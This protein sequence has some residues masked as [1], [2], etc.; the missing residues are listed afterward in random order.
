VR[1]FIGHWYV[2]DATLDITSGSAGVE[3]G[4]AGPC[5][6]NDTRHCSE[7]DTLSFALS[8][9]GS[10]VATIATITYTDDETS[11]SVPNPHPGDSQA[12]GDSSRLG[13]VA[14]HLMKEM[15]VRSHLPPI[16][17][18]G[19]NPY[20]CQDGLAANLKDRCGA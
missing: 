15:I 13:I 11:A 17:L 7:R 14:P 10:M 16:D 18:Q 6:P 5:G 9:D 4:N 19:G 12:V 20:W 8:E 1:Q 3:I 2:H